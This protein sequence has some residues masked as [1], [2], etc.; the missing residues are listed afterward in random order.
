MT[1]ENEN[2]VEDEVD[3]TLDDEN[4]ESENEEQSEEDTNEDDTKDDEDTSQQDEEGDT[5]ILIGDE[6]PE[7]EETESAPQWVK[8]LRKQNREQAK[9]IKELEA[10]A[11]DQDK[12]VKLGEKPKL[13]DFDY[14]EDKHSAALEDWFNKKSEI[15]NQKNQEEQRQKQEQERYDKKLA[16][17]NERKVQLKV[18]DFETLESRV[19]EG[20]SEMQQA[21][22]VS[23]TKK[24]EEVIAALGQH[25]RRLMELSKLED[26][27]EFIA[28]TVRLEMSMK[29]ATRKKPA[30][31]RKAPASTSGFKGGTDK[32]LEKLEAEAE[33]TGDRTKILQY[34]KSLRNK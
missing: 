19:S 2:P 14:D 27:V 29:T 10:K 11:S 32:T 21:I 25:P 9:R 33:R 6:E 17:Y 1:L 16:G 12:T 13:E 18:K 4:A 30:P 20:L 23:A 34:K 15:D 5:I 28:E 3:E 22:I 26:P 7:E 31:E 8:D 24:P